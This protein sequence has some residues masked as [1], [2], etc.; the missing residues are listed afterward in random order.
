M[1]YHYQ[2]AERP[3]Q[4]KARWIICY[5]WRNTGWSG[6]KGALI[7]AWGESDLHYYKTNGQYCSVFQMGTDERRT[8]GANPCL[9][10]GNNIRGARA[11]NKSYGWG[12]WSCKPYL[13]YRNPCKKPPNWVLTL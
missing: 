9:H 4:E 2:S 8:W 6:C 5:R 1:G 3:S 13:D 12:P 7:V 10:G 11:Y